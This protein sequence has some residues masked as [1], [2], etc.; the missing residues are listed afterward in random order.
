MKRISMQSALALAK[1]LGVTGTQ[2]YYMNGRYMLGFPFQTWSFAIDQRM[3]ALK[4]AVTK[5]VP[6][7]E[8]YER[9]ISEG[10]TEP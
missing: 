5:G 6:R 2:T 9:I 7:S 4:T 8:V 1:S 3:G 10:K